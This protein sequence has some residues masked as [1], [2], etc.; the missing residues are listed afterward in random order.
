MERQL[1]AVLQRM[2][3]LWNGGDVDPVTVYADNCL[4]DGGPET[5]QPSEVTP[6]IAD[7]RSAF[8]DLRWAV[9][10]WFSTGDRYVLRMQAKGTHTGSTFVSA[11]GET[12]ASGNPVVLKGIEVF[13]VRD[14]NRR[15]LAGLGLRSALHSP[16][17]SHLASRRPNQL[18]P[19]ERR[20]PA[21]VFNGLKLYHRPTSRTFAAGTPQAT[22][23]KRAR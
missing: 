15:R 6:I 10:E 17:G 18:P 23:V 19:G 16:R 14:E 9:E 11:L 3:D 12:A 21:P 2:L 5:F 4:S 1:P 8:P 13:E 22:F 20:C 7:Y